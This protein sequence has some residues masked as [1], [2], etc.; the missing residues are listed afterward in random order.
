V[1]VIWS[2]AN[3]L[4]ACG[5]AWGKVSAISHMLRKLR[6]NRAAPQPPFRYPKPKRK[7]A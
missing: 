4:T 2:K 6:P 3:S 1:L 7:A 5:E